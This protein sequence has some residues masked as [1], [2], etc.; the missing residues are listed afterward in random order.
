MIFMVF[1]LCALTVLA[2]LGIIILYIVVE[3]MGVMSWDFLTQDP[4]PSP[5]G[6]MTRGG[7][8]SP[9]IGTFYLLLLVLGFSI[10]VGILGAVFLTEYVGH[11]KWSRYLWVIIHNL[12]GVPSIVYGLLGVA[13]F[14]WY[15]GFGLSLLAAGLTLGIMVLPII[16]VATREALDAVP[17]SL[18]EASVALGC[19]KWQTI[20][21]HVLPYSASGILTGTILSLSRAGGETAPILVTGVA[22][23]AALPSSVMEPFQAL[24]YHIYIM[25]TQTSNI[26]ESYPVAWGAALVLVAL[27]VFMNA[28]AVLLRNRYRKKYRW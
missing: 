25:V 19:T 23:N 20:R 4:M 22:A 17:R 1:R 18:R 13:L 28:F 21:H 16:M 14:V 6:S 9:L 26:K 3:G 10:P 7:I 15:L 27:V 8:F 24:P 12:A 11:L 5:T 2:S